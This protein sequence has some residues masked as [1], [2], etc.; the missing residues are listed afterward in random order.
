MIHRLSAA[1]LAV[2]VAVGLP[3]AAS[4]QPAAPLSE[5]LTDAFEGVFGAHPGARRSGARGVCATGEWLS[6][7]AGAALSTAATLQAGVRA[8]VTAR[9][10]V[11]GGN[12]M[13]PENAPSVRGL[14]LEIDGPGGAPHAFVLINTPVFTARTPDS[15]LA[16]LRARAI[17]PQTRQPNA[18]AIAA[19]NAQHP[20]W[21]PQMAYL[22]DTPP[23]A[24][25]ATAPYFGVNSF[26][27]VNAAGQRQHVRWT[28]E[29]VAGRIGLTPAERQA[30][31]ATFLNA[32]L[33]TR[34]AA[35]PAEWRVLVQLPEAGD[36]L[37]DAVTA[38]PAERRTIEVARLRITG[39]ATTDGVGPCEG[40]MFNPTLLPDGIEASED[41][42]L[43][44]RAE[45]YAVSLSR[46]SR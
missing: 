26:V 7:G 40:G 6:T 43:T 33:R 8:P 19:A 30:R 17:D 16:F 14:S 13:A 41:P 45:V 46:R 28:F 18:A 3:A 4:A 23:P 39:V 9:F 35:M 31:G 12:P 25:Y 22:R 15:M 5:Q 10:S 38:W 34:V 36:P 29:P 44:I 24:S 1:A 20:D 27:L 11:G 37:N 21:Q 42:V 32:E 2:V